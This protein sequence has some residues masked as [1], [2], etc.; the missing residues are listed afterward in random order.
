MSKL[1]FGRLALA[2]VMTSW[3]A[4]PIA[5]ARCHIS[6][7]SPSTLNGS[8]SEYVL[9]L[10]GTIYSEKASVGILCQSQVLSS[11]HPPWAPALCPSSRDRA[12]KDA[13]KP[14]AKLHGQSTFSIARIEVD[15]R[16]RQTTSPWYCTPVSSS[17]MIF[18]QQYFQCAAS[19]C[20][21]I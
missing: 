2:K 9:C 14:F 1:W 20:V 11:L 12:R 8:D 7:T 21:T 17:C 3:N 16:R 18:T 13:R 10:R 6:Q 4:L 5:G 19:D 15:L